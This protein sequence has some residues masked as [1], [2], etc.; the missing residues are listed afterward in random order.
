MLENIMHGLDMEH[1][2][3]II[4]EKI[5][6]I[7]NKFEICIV[8]LK[9]CNHPESFIKINFGYN[10]KKQSLL[11]CHIYTNE[12]NKI[13][14]FYYNTNTDEAYVRNKLDFNGKLIVSSDK[15]KIES[16]EHLQEILQKVIIET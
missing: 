16:L 5:P 10:S 12:F 4:E 9:L 7:R 1:R 2:W 3:E 11:R 8:G 15:I 6:G 14:S 13:F